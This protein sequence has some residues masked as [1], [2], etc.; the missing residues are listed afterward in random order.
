MKIM[1]FYGGVECT[2]GSG[3]ITGMAH[4]KL[5]VYVDHGNDLLRHIVYKSCVYKFVRYD[6][7]SMQCVAEYTF[8]SPCNILGDPNESYKFPGA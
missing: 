7:V 8:V 4:E 5:R 2:D 3:N 1:A 6:I